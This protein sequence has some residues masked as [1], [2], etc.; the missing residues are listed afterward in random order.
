MSPVSTNVPKGYRYTVPMAFKYSD[1]YKEWCDAKKN[2]LKKLLR[3]TSTNGNLSLQAVIEEEKQWSQAHKDIRKKSECVNI[4]FQQIQKLT[5]ENHSALEDLRKIPKELED[6]FS[7]L[8][9][10]SDNHF[11]KIDHAKEVI[12]TMDFFKDL[13]EVIVSMCDMFASGVVNNLNS[14]YFM[15]EVVKLEKEVQRVF[16]RATVKLQTVPAYSECLMNKHQEL[17][18]HL[19]TL[20]QSAS[21]YLGQPVEDVSQNSINQ[22]ANDDGEL[23]SE[24]FNSDDD[25]TPPSLYDLYSHLDFWRHWAKRVD[26]DLQ[27]LISDNSHKK[28]RSL[29]STLKYLYEMCSLR[30]GFRAMIDDVY[31]TIADAEESI[32]SEDFTAGVLWMKK[33]NLL[34]K[35][36]HIDRKTHRTWKMMSDSVDGIWSSRQNNAKSVKTQ[37]AVCS[38]PKNAEPEKDKIIGE[39]NKNVLKRKRVAF[40]NDGREHK[41]KRYE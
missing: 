29:K 4:L 40:D 24:N 8:E 12:S 13:E 19:T 15:A 28:P 31:E 10:I 1:R 22:I 27:E 7:E 33:S 36:E 32:I 11:E 38:D 14:S 18:R 34:Q 30:K 6:V 35:I 39:R 2:D 16:L 9:V 37:N 5:S 41:T 23:G 3:N 21:K 25:A 26:S 20:K 17:I